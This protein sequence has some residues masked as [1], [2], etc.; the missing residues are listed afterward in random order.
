MSHPRPPNFLPRRLSSGVR[1]LS[2]LSCLVPLAGCEPRD[3]HLIPQGYVGPV[4]IVFDDPR[5]ERVDPARREYRVPPGGVLHVTADGEGPHRPVF[6]AVS[7]S[8]ERTLLPTEEGAQPG[9]Q[10]YGLQW[11][12]QVT[13]G[14]SV[15][16]AAQQ[17]LRYQVYL[18][19]DPREGRDGEEEVER[20][21][22][23]AWERLR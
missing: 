10:V 13:F 3:V 7:A 21:L 6:Y 17:R 19:D 15:P 23:A 8:G 14:A 22:D 12:E 11:G 16:G 20:R 18:V 4:L 9:L 2:L 5:G 1:L